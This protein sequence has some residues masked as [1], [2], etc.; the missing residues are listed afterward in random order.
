MSLLL[1]YIVH[2]NNNHQE[3]KSVEL[4]IPLHN[5]CAQSN[6]RDILSIAREQLAIDDACTST[7]LIRFKATLKN[8]YFYL[9]VLMYTQKR[10]LC[11]RNVQMSYLEGRLKLTVRTKFV[12]SE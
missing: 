4:P 12:N 6:V 8:N 5:S 11:G 2:H 1:S 9:R 7:V 10:M 3:E